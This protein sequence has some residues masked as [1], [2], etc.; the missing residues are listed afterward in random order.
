MIV[1]LTYQEM[2]R[3]IK[4]KSGKKIRMEYVDSET[5]KLCYNVKVMMF[6][7]EISVD[8]RVVGIEGCV[9]KVEFVDKGIV[10]LAIGTIINILSFNF[11]STDSDNQYILVDT[12]QIKECEEVYKRA[13]L[14]SLS[15]DDESVNLTME[16]IFND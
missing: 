6:E 15:F 12:A 16:L 13:T 1:K 10:N 8:L 9:V 4:N 14:Q 11:I 3:L 7:K 5:I 2:E